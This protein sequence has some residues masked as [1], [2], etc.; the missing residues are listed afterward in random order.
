MADQ[1]SAGSR[2]KLKFPQCIVC[3]FR[4]TCMAF[5]IA[6]IAAVASNKQQHG[7]VQHTTLQKFCSIIFLDP[8]A[9]FLHV[10]KICTVKFKSKVFKLALR[11]TSQEA[12]MCLPPH[13]QGEPKIGG[14]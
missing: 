3:H 1:V 14:Q 12:D 2:C 9:L 7:R 8:A 11:S 6:G 10:G 5:N 13:I 4:G